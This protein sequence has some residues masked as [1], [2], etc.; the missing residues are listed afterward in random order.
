MFIIGTSGHIDHGKSALVQALTG[1]NPDRLPEEQGSL[2][3]PRAAVDEL[4]AERL[5]RRRIAVRDLN[6]QTAAVARSELEIAPDLH[7]AGMRKRDAGAPPFRRAS[8]S[9]TATA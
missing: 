9:T 5:C 6:A 2:A 3:G 7:R 4:A 1:I 8:L